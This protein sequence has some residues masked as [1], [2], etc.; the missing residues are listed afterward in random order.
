[1]TFYILVLPYILVYHV[2]PTQGEEDRIATIVCY[3]IGVILLQILGS[4]RAYYSWKSREEVVPEPPALYYD[5]S[6]KQSDDGLVGQIT[7]FL[8]KQESPKLLPTPRPKPPAAFDYTN[9][10]NL[11]ELA[12]LTLE[13][14]QMATFALQNNPYE[15]TGNDP[16]AAPTTAPS[17]SDE[18]SDASTSFWGPNVF[19]VLYIDLPSAQDMQFIIMWS[20]VGVVWAL[21]LIF[22]GQ[23][24]MEL[25][26]YG[27]LMAR[28][29]DSDKAKD[30]FF[31]SFTGSIVYG[32]GKPRN[33]SESMRLIVGLLS[34]GLFLIISF[35]LLQAFSCDYT[36]NG[37]PTLRADAS[38][39]CWEG[40]HAVVGTAALISYALYVPLSIMISPML[41]EAP[42]K[43]TKPGE[44]PQE[45]TGVSYMK[46]YLMFINTVKSIMLVVGVLGP[47]TVTTV[48]ISST[49]SSCVLGIMTILWY[50]SYVPTSTHYSSTPEPCNIAFINYWKA[51]SYV[52]AVSSALIV[53]AAYELTADVF[54]A[55][56][57]TTA[58]IVS[59]IVIIVV[60]AVMYYR[61]HSKY[62]QRMDLVR[63]LITYPFNI[64]DYKEQAVKY[65]HEGSPMWRGIK[66]FP[67]RLAHIPGF[68]VSPWADKRA[69]IHQRFGV[70]PGG[71]DGDIPIT[72]TLVTVVTDDDE[73][74]TIDIFH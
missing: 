69:E 18:S 13:F 46:L 2:F 61:Y 21:I 10:S 60:F 58:L 25:K 38:I 72:G 12:S 31:Y 4:V 39:V 62:D 34:D 19:E 63:D 55:N 22:V 28:I 47:E 16:T 11:M 66:E 32:H 74:Q 50:Q 68:M 23:F 26:L 17:A 52:A 53:I 73:L 67:T 29:E 20:S 42:P 27:R 54:P 51:A 3:V 64:R 14:F 70:I 57:L 43:P 24:L 6:L 7:S 33:I 37:S 40:R 30:S 48:V 41:L 36:G 59:W 71:V 44:P 15:S 45:N 9:P 8:K 35:Q 56:G 1:M 65:Q 49:A 5:P